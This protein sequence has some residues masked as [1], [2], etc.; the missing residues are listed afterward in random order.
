MAKFGVVLVSHSEYIAKGLKELVDEM[1]DGS[2]QVVAAGGADGG[3]IGTSAI[4]IQGAIES[5]ED[6]DHILIYADLGSS[7]LSAETAIDLIDEASS[8]ARLKV[9]VMPDGIKK[10]EEEIKALEAEKEEAIKR[11]AYE[12]AGEIKKKQLR[13]K[14]RIEKLKEKWETQRTG[15]EIVVGEEEIADVVAMWTKI[16]VTKIAQAES[17]RLMQLEETLHHRVVGQEEA[18]ASV[19]KAIR[20]GRVGLKDPNRPIGSFLFLGPTGCL[21]YTSDAAD[22]L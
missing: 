22:E 11:E 10:A 12:E 16:P 4:K 15:S 19:A 14:E 8:K 18:V 1:N 2:V 7:I 17:E 21:L 6:C 5:V 3:R 20:R 9:Y 13:K